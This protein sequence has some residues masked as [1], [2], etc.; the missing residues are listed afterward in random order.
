MSD[1]SSP[2]SPSPAVFEHQLRALRRITIGVA[3]AAVGALALAVVAV[4]RTPAPVVLPAPARAALPPMPSK[5]DELTVGRLNVVEPDGTPRMIVSSRARFPGSFVRGKEIARPDRTDFA[6]ILFVDDEGTENG[7]LIQEG[8]LDKDGKV[9]A[10]ASLT[11]DRFRQD[12]MVQLLFDED[13]D[14]AAAG[15]I[16]N[17]R[18]SYKVFSIDDLM[19]LS[20]E[21]RRL[22]PA[23]RDAL[24]RR[25]DEQGRGGHRRG[26]FGLDQ[27]SSKL[28]LNDPHGRPRLVLRVSDR[29]EPSIE[30]LDEAG[31]AVQ[32]VA[33]HQH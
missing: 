4:L 32:T 25:N 7:G 1:P 9:V 28:V 2:S 6:G 19:R 10:A 27:G 21:A 26:Y 14:T 13:G 15:L 12:Q 20:D 18:P 22:P 24:F 33:A 17:D 5:L 3:I 11:F 29:G 8:K 31:H 23:E 16:I 30:L